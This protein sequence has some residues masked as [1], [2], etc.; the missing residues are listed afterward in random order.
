MKGSK[1]R[2]QLSGILGSVDCESF[3]EDV[4]SFTEFGNRHLLFSVVRSAKLIEM[5][6]KRDINCS[7]SSDYFP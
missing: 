4:Q 7:T 5:D 1:L 3:G 6:A 2:N